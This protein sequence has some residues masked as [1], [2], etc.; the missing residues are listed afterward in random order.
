MTLDL[1][2]AS[3]L[4]RDKNCLGN[5]LLSQRA[6][7]TGQAPPEDNEHTLRGTRV[8]EGKPEGEDEE[9]ARAKVIA[10]AYKVFDSLSDG[11]PFQVIAEREFLLR[12]DGLIPYFIGHPDLF[13]VT[14]KRIAFVDIKPGFE[15][16]WEAWKA[17]MDGYVALLFENLATLHTQDVV[18]TVVTRFHGNRE[19]RYTP[20]DCEKIIND[21]AELE[22]WRVDKTTGGPWCK[23]CDARLICRDAI[24]FPVEAVDPVT[25]SAVA[26]KTDSLPSGELGAE[27]VTKLKLI[28]KI[29]KDRL[30]WYEEQLTNDSQ[31]LAGK[32]VIGKG[33]EI[34]F[35]SNPRA[36]WIKTGNAPNLISIPIG[37]LEQWC[38]M[39]SVSINDFEDFISTKTTKGSMKAS[40]EIEDK[41]P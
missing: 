12:H 18:G 16:D 5:R 10:E 34:R 33:K 27:I 20:S 15:C 36:A 24:K 29:A 28:M 19:W 25:E 8:H 13:I 22:S 14:S 35:V 7:A 1:L 17:Q 6:R 2:R 31:F 37:K 41:Q 40:N 30:A 23:Y 4:Y 38:S 32:Y 9:Q 3:S 11:E 21:I 39:N 26:I